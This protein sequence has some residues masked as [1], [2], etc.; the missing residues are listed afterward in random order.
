MERFRTAIYAFAAIAALTPAVAHAEDVPRG[1]WSY[2][3]VQDLAAKGLIAGYPSDPN[4]FQGRTVTRYEMA[5]LVGRAVGRLTALQ[6]AGDASPTPATFD[7]VGKLL[8]DY[9]VELA[10]MGT[11]ITTL[12]LGV[13]KLTGQ[14]L[15]QQKHIDT[16]AKTKV[17]SGVATGVHFSSLM[18]EWVAAGDD[19]ANTGKNPGAISNTFRIRRAEFRFTGNID[20]KTYFNIMLDPSKNLSLNP[21]ATKTTVAGTTITTTTYT[22]KNTGVP[23][24]DF[25]LGYKLSPQFSFE[26]GQEKIPLSIEGY[27]ASSNLL[28]VERSLMNDGA[29]YGQGQVGDIRDQGAYLKFNQPK[30]FNATLAVT[31][32]AGADQNQVDDNNFKS[33]LYNAQITAVRNLQF[34]AYGELPDRGGNPTILARR[35]TGVDFGYIDATNEVTG[36]YET[37]QDGISG[38]SLNYNSRSA[39]G[40]FAHKFGPHLQGVVRE[41]WFQ[42]VGPATVASGSITSSTI[43]T[44]DEHDLTLGVNYYVHGNNE[45]F[46]FNYI[47]KTIGGP[48]TPSSS[49]TVGPQNQPALGVSRDQWFLGMQQWF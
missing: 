7:E 43:V 32:D 6:D 20:S 5:A 28:T 9:K 8:A 11:D 3:A 22:V 37:G 44:N 15:D 25:I 40:I 31:N 13:Q 46:Q 2:S 49:A 1:D 24:Q 17:D 10:V 35:R 23:L 41:D 18:Q 30:A 12:K 48:L 29:A 38:S 27:R 21:T 19:I 14:V 33:V 36:E 39:Y 45:K 47:R 16:L 4:L 26:A 34:G 42:G